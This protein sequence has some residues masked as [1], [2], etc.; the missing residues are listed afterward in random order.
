MAAGTLDRVSAALRLDTLE[1]KYLRKLV[2]NH[3]RTY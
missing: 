2:Y 3:G 1:N